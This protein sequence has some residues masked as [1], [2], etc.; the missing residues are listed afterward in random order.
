MGGFQVTTTCAQIANLEGRPEI[1]L[2]VEN[3]G[4]RVE[5][6]SGLTAAFG[7]RHG[8]PRYWGK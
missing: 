8:S 5:R 4:G 6:N 7:L 1:G 2:G 3:F